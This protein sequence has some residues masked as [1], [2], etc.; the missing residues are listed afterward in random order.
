MV[1]LRGPCLAMASRGVWGPGRA[2]WG[3]GLHSG[4]LAMRPTAPCLNGCCIFCERLGARGVNSGHEWA[5]GTRGPQTQPPPSPTG[6]SPG[7]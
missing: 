5:G 2:G 4:T 1:P 6:S 3:C 7:R